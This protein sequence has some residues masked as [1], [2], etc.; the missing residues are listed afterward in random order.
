MDISRKISLKKLH[1]YFYVT[2]TN[3][4]TAD[5]HPIYVIVK[6]FESAHDFYDVYMLK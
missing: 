6:D 4:H 3:I 2:C 5:W 1:Q